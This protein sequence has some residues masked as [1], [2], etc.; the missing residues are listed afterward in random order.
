MTRVPVVVLTGHLGSGKTTMLN[1]LLRRPGARVGVI[2]NDF[3]AVNIDA[4]L[5]SG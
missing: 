5:V 1:F 4:G 3:G 2:V